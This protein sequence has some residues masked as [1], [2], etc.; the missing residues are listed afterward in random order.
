M[1]RAAEHH[2]SLPIPWGGASAGPDL[3][4]AGSSQDPYATSY[5]LNARAAA[6]RMVANKSGV[7]MTV[8]ALHSRTGIQLVGGY[9]PRIR[10]TGRLRGAGR[11]PG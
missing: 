6:R 5:F 11:R 1:A 10:R 9:G 8:T 4:E 7:I 2:P 3:T